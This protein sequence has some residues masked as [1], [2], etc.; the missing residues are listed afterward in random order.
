MGY[1]RGFLVEDKPMRGGET[2]VVEW[3]C[4]G[5]GDWV[6]LGM[7]ESDVVERRMEDE[8][9]ELPSDR[10]RGRGVCARC[11]MLTAAG[12]LVVSMVLQKATPADD[13]LVK[14]W[15]AMA[16]HLPSGMEKFAR[17]VLSPGFIL[18][19]FV[20]TFLWVVLFMILW[21][22]GC[23]VRRLEKHR[24]LLWLS[25]FFAMGLFVL[26]AMVPL[27][28]PPAHLRGYYWALLGGSAL[29][30]VGLFL[31]RRR[32]GCGREG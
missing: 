7:A 15:Q 28:H 11:V 23:E 10:E 4:E 3:S 14:A 13:C 8:S 12:L 18:T 20:V 25:R 22:G 19:M 29:G 30:M 21:V 24:F 27:T 5:R 31:V 26:V 9:A 32:R 1:S 16:V 17:E 6:S 2:G